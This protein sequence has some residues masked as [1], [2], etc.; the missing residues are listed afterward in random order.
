MGWFIK[1]SAQAKN[2]EFQIDPQMIIRLMLH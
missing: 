1:E 2:L